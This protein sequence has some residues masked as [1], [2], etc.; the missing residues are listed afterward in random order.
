MSVSDGPQS[1]ASSW[2]RDG[3]LDRHGC[4]LE[5]GHGG[6]HECTCGDVYPVELRL[7]EPLVDT[8]VPEQETD[9]RYYEYRV[10]AKKPG[11]QFR[12][13]TFGPTES[14]PYRAEEAVR[15]AQ[16]NNPGWTF[17]LQRR[18]VSIYASGWAEFDGCLAKG[19]Q[20]KVRCLKPPGHPA[21]HEWVPDDR[22]GGA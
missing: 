4:S 8:R 15:W 9:R 10:M 19:S 6:P 1:C 22:S 11:G 21:P 5:T 13:T 3:D 20:A 12:T 17:R 16:N 18:S 14:L 2:P 7:P